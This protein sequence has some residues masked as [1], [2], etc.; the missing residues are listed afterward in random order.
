MASDPTLCCTGSWVVP[1]CPRCWNYTPDTQQL[2]GLMRS[3]ALAH[4]G[5]GKNILLPLKQV[6]EKALWFQSLS[7]ITQTPSAP[8]T[9]AAKP[10]QRAKGLL[11]SLPSTLIHLKKQLHSTGKKKQHQGN[12]SVPIKKDTL[13]PTLGH[14]VSRL[15]PVPVRGTGNATSWGMET[16]PG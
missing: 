5:G 8:S 12:S 9:R 3:S 15:V 13:C 14:K 16:F 11:V 10:T 7:S 1:D 6:A 2:L 4:L